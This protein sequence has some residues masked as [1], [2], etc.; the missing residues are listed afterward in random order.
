MGEVCSKKTYFGRYNAVNTK[1]KPGFDI[2]N[3]RHF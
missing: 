1:K 3:T 2:A